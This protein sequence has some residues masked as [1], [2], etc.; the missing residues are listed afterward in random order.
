MKH[1]D[2]YLF[3]ADGTL[4]DTAEMIYHCF[5]N[6]CRHF[7]NRE[8]TREEI[9][10]R[11][12]IPLRPQVEMLI[13]KLSDEQY[14]EVQQF[15]MVYQNSI[16][17]QYLSAFP[18]SGPVL[19][20]LKTIGKR[21]VIVTSRRIES[22]SVYLDYT[23][24]AEFFEFCI[25]PAETEKHKPDP[26]PALLAAQRLGIDPAHCLFIGDAIFDIDCGNSAGMDTAFVLWSTNRAEDLVTRPTYLL[27][28]WSELLPD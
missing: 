4:L 1:Y 18:G 10:A 22:L 25:T 20:H 3:D 7:G 26:E 21:L 9:F 13:G 23:G 11:I 24:L 19:A 12:G 27:S 16:F 5:V 17:K 15:H 14:H 6:T 2:A 8:V 28:S